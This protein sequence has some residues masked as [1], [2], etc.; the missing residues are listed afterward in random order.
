M[1]AEFTADNSWSQISAAVSI[2]DDK[3][4]RLS[5]ARDTLQV[6]DLTDGQ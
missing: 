3:L 2:K 5:V 1:H 4:E 6:C